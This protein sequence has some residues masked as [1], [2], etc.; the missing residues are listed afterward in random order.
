MEYFY[1]GGFLF[2]LK[3]RIF[4]SGILSKFTHKRKDAHQIRGRTELLT[5]TEPNTEGTRGGQRG[6][7]EAPLQ[8]KTSAIEGLNKEHGVSYRGGEQTGLCFS[9]L[10][11]IIHLSL[12]HPKVQKPRAPETNTVF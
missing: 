9:V 12:F 8:R 7:K 11:C 2:F 5:P 4:H 1:I 10:S 3:L 6:D